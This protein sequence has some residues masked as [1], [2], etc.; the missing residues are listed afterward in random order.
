MTIGTDH[1]FVR[2]FFA[3]YVCDF[4]RD[5]SCIFSGEYNELFGV[6]VVRVQLV[7]VQQLHP[8]LPDHHHR[9]SGFI[10]CRTA[11]RSLWGTVLFWWIDLGS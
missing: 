7:Y 5:F 4:Y 11:R 10:A 2:I 3:V 1:L 8:E 9:S 6:P